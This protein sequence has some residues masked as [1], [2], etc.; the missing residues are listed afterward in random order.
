MKV[1]C[2]DI[3]NTWYTIDISST[4]TIAAVYMVIV[5]YLPSTEE[6]NRIRCVCLNGNQQNCYDNP[7]IWIV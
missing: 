3:D 5:S 4:H 6:K 7:S 1:F 2:S